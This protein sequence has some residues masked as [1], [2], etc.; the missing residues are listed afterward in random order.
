MY[1]YVCVCVCVCVYIYIYQ[2]TY[3]GKKG[4]LFDTLED[5]DADDVLKK[6]QQIS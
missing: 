5:M 1:M 6:A 2:V 4:S 3:K